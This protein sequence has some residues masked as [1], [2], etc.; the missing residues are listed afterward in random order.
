MH[1]LA[2]TGLPA[3]HPPV[4][5]LANQARKEGS[6][7]DFA[8]Y[9][10]RYQCI[11]FAREDG[12]LE[13]RMHTRGGPAKWGT[14]L[15]SLHAELGDA[16]ARLALDRENKVVLFT[17]TGDVFLTEFDDQEVSPEADASQ[18]WAR[19]HQEGMELLNNLLAVPVPM[20]AAVNGPATLHAELA[21]LC[22]VVLAADHAEFA[23]LAHVPNGTVPG[24][25]VHVVWPM[26]LGPNRGR[27][28]LLT[29]ERIDAGE[30][31]RLGLVGEV[32]PLPD[33]MPRARELAAKL[34]ALP[35]PMLR[36]TRAILIRDLRARM[37]NELSAG[38]A[39]EGLGILSWG[40]R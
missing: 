25:G 1:A 12:V 30:A 10:N 29:G 4:D 21:M 19:I 27:Y 22:D 20:I 36:H 37:I 8:E 23:D 16:F 18:M 40:A 28:F 32:L 5:S 9:A 2:T 35:G 14:T 7:V 17:A 3:C 13:M 39:H 26:L 6:L 31:K 33:L 24:D 11:S 15:N 34:A 38:L